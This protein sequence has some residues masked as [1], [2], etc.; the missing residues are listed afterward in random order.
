MPPKESGNI[1]VQTAKAQPKEDSTS[2]SHQFIQDLQYACRLP[3]L[4][5]I[6]HSIRIP[7]MSRRYPMWLHETYGGFGSERRRVMMCIH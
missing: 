5:L 7:W 6:G 4:S 3:S 1:Y 2:P